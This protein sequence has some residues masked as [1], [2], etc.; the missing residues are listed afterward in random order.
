MRLTVFMPISAVLLL[1]AC[2]SGSGG[3]MVMGR[4]GSPAWFATASQET[5]IQ[6][7]EGIC[8]RYGYSS[9][10]SEMSQCLQTEMQGGKA[11]SSEAAKRGTDTLNSISRAEA[12]RQQRNQSV[13]CNSSGTVKGN[14]VNTTTTC[15]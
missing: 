4:P 12:E 11:R 10:T 2:A 13:T 3:E 6:Y 9:G 15:R 14:M 8:R 1:N 7:F 5:Q